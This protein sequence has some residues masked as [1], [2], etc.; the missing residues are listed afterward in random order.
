[1]G[2]ASWLLIRFHSLLFRCYCFCYENYFVIIVIKMKVNSFNL[3][4]KVEV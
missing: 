1:M 2:D 3:K 4:C